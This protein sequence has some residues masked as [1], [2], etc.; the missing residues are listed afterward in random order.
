MEKWEQDRVAERG[1]GPASWTLMPDFEHHFETLRAIA[2][3]PAPGTAG[4]VLPRYDP[5]WGE[6]FWDFVNR[7]I[8][9]WEKDAVRDKLRQDRESFRP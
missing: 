3:D 8:E 2:G 9:W 4:R 7:R 6:V 5:K 1:D